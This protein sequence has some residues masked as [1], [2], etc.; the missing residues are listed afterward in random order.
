MTSSR[1]PGRDRRRKRR[2]DGEEGCCAGMLDTC[3]G[4]RQCCPE[5]W[6]TLLPALFLALVRPSNGRRPSRARRP[7]PDGRPPGRVAG[8]LYTA[9]QYYRDEISPGRPPCCPYTPSCST[10]A[11]KALG[12]HGAVRGGRLTVSRL[13]RCRPAAA[14]RRGYTDPVPD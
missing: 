1:K 4:Y 9:V 8:A 12:R 13:L 10:Y 2:E 6:L 14:R 11:V 3:V 5:M 7:S